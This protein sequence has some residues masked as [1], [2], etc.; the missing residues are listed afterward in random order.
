MVVVGTQASPGVVRIL[1]AYLRRETGVQ[2]YLWTT[3]RTQALATRDARRRPLLMTDVGGGQGT[4]LQPDAQ[5]KSS[6]PVSSK[7]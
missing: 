7:W 6:V 3:I 2:R 4:A 1:L 5:E